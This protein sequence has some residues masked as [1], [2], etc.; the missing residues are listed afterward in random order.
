MSTP[1]APEPKDEQ[2]ED[3]QDP[4]DTEQAE[5]YEESEEQNDDYAQLLSK[6]LVPAE[7]AVEKIK[8]METTADIVRFIA[9]ENRQT[10]LEAAQKRI[11]QLT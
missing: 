3:I 7:K 1:S 4:E 8:K 5:G 10:V 2:P 9:G 11:D 6:D